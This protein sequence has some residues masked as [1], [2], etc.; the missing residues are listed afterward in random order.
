[1]TEADLE[2]E[3]MLRELKEL[4]TKERERESQK[5]R[6]QQ[7]MQGSSPC[8]PKCGLR[9]LTFPKQCRNWRG[10]GGSYRLNG[11]SIVTPLAA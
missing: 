7:T 1:M 8:D 9:K 10:R 4:R 11:V 3:E 2:R 6:W 5:E